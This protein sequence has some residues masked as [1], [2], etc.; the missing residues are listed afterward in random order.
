MW[1]VPF[2]LFISL[3]ANDLALPQTAEAKSAAWTGDDSLQ[4]PLP[5]RVNK[6]ASLLKGFV[7]FCFECGGWFWVFFMF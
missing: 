3:S 1:L 6:R 5:S 2:A 7:S 4:G